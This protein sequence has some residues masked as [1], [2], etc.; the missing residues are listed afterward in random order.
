MCRMA[1]APD[2][3]RGVGFLHYP[4]DRVGHFEVLPSTVQ[5]AP[6]TAPG[7]F[8]A[9]VFLMLAKVLRHRADK[10]PVPSRNRPVVVLGAQL[11]NA[12]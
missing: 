9:P 1:D 6:P 10:L 11:I 7:S 2:S 12:Y 4:P 8:A 5:P 3:I